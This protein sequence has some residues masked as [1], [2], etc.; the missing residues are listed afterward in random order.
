[1]K[2]TFTCRL[3][4]VLVAV[5]AFLPVVE[6]VHGSPQPCASERRAY[7][8]AD[9]EVRRLESDQRATVAGGALTVAGTAAV[10]GVKGAV[11]GAGKGAAAGAVLGAPTGPGAIAT[12]KAGAVANGL[13]EG[14]KAAVEAAVITTVALA[15]IVINNQAKINAAKTVRSEKL[16]ALD[17]CLEGDKRSCRGRCSTVK[18]NY[19][20]SMAEAT[21]RHWAC[22]CNHGGR[23][24]ECPSYSAGSGS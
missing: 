6:A 21:G 24:R 4:L 19:S 1:M 8:T 9:Q 23:C 2:S 7:N 10:K 13:R 22:G 20:K 12:A 16:G 5:I 3:T 17:R 11:K 18:T 15:P 14:G